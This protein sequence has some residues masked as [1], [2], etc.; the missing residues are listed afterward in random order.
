MEERLQRQSTPNRSQE[1]A[2]PLATRSGS[3]EMR[4]DPPKVHQPMPAGHVAQQF[5]WLHELPQGRLFDIR[6][7]AS[8]SDARSLIAAACGAP[9]G[10]LEELGRQ[11]RATMEKVFALEELLRQEEEAHQERL[12]ALRSEHRVEKRRGKLRLLARYAPHGA[13]A[14]EALRCE[15]AL[16][17]ESTE[18]GLLLAEPRGLPPSPVLSRPA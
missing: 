2:E 3:S 18:A 4:A 12:E 16:P 8:P 9:R 10:V 11:T 17:P 14:R 1:S 15:A 6:R 5:E 7:C 13:A